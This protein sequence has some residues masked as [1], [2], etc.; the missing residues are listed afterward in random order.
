MRFAP[1]ELADSQML[2]LRRIHPGTVMKP[3][4]RQV[5]VPA[6]TDGKIGGSKIV[7]LELLAWIEE[8]LVLL[9][10]KGSS[11]NADPDAGAKNHN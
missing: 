5:L 8:V 4:V 3:A 2:R 9:S 1:V 10:T 6:P 11:L 7:G